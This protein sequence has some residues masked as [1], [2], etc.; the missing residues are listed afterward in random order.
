MLWCHKQLTYK[1]S[2]LK[3]TSLKKITTTSGQSSARRKHW[4]I[5]VLYI[6]NF[7]VTSWSMGWKSIMT[8]SRKNMVFICFC[9]TFYLHDLSIV[10]YYKNFAHFTI[11][12]ATVSNI[13]YN[14][15]S[16]PASKK[17]VSL[18]CAM[19]TRRLVAF[20]NKEKVGFRYFHKQ[21]QGLQP[22]MLVSPQ[23]LVII[24][25]LLTL[26]PRAAV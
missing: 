19:M 24:H 25:W 12:F 14:V 22:S 20:L 26:K 18:F 1:Y 11:F 15:I 21:W 4:D 8:F 23:T 2:L 10:H 6:W 16:K 9:L 5:C 17:F 7:S 13:W 3:W